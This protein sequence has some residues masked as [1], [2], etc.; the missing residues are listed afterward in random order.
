M[1]L[2]GRQPLDILLIGDDDLLGLTLALT[3]ARRRIVVLDAD[4]ELLALVRR[5]APERT[6]EIVEHDVHHVLPHRLRGCFDE[7]FTDPPYTLAGQL[8]FVHRAVWALRPCPGA[9]L[10]VCASR[11]YMAEPQLS[12]VRCFLQLAGFE[13]A[14]RYLD[15]NRYKAPPDVRCDLKEQGV[16]GTAWL[17]SDL[18]YYVRRRAADLPSA[19]SV[20]K[21]GIYEYKT[22]VNT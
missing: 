4:P 18:F 2:L 7:V 17:D 14:G 19:P 6:L 1:R 5:F 12:T 15:F 13:L 22:R 20:P 21:G 3:A 11:A 9:G 16:R 10:Y 8:L